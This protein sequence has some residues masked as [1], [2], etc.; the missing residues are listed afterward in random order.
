MAGSQE[1]WR[2]GHLLLVGCQGRWQCPP[3]QGG[4]RGHTASRPSPRDL[5]LPGEARLA[6]SKKITAPLCSKV[7]L[8]DSDGKKNPRQKEQGIQRRVSRPADQGHRS[9]AAAHPENV[10][11]CDSSNIMVYLSAPGSVE[12]KCCSRYWGCP[13]APLAPRDW[14]RLPGG[15][16]AAGKRSS[17]T[18]RTQIQ[19]PAA[20]EGELTPSSWSRAGS[21]GGQA[22]Q[23][24][25]TG[26]PAAEA[27]R[28]RG[29]L[30]GSRACSD[31]DSV[32]ITEH[33]VRMLPKNRSLPFFHLKGNSVGRRLRY[34][35]AGARWG[36]VHR[37]P[38]TGSHL[39]IPGC[40]SGT[41]HQSQAGSKG[42]VL[43]NALTTH[44][45]AQPLSTLE[46]KPTSTFHR[47][48]YCKTNP[49]L[50]KAALV[51]RGSGCDQPSPAFSRTSF[52]V[53]CCFTASSLLAGVRRNVCQQI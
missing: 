29:L 4:G 22:G 46:Q 10:A 19:P 24:E 14:H 47:G 30:C 44:V 16:G 41:R 1:G 2:L 13:G 35:R 27:G 38:P 7:I 48:W 8:N 43:R 26:S 49:S 31:R 51:P 25:G 52:T 23:E 20:G 18:W 45:G 17:P 28:A 36:L 3:A 5:L 33:L 34:S 32:A 53:Q 37:Q 9:Q 21:S 11:P 12:D 15:G 6:A 42:L 40:D 39:N 50:P